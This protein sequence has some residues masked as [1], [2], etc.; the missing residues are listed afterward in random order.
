MISKYICHLL[1]VRYVGTYFFMLG[2]AI[3]RGYLGE[4]DMIK[5]GRE[6]C[7]NVKKKEEKR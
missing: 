5:K 3:N 2:D 7:K 6:K 1:F 4:G